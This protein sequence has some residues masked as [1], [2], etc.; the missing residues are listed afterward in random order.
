MTK[1]DT[2]NPQPSQPPPLFIQPATTQ[3][4]V[5]HPA[6][7]HNLVH[8]P[9]DTTTQIR[10]CPFW[11]RRQR[12]LA[13][14]LR[15][16]GKLSRRGSRV[17]GWKRRSR[18]AAAVVVRLYS[19]FLPNTAGEER[20]AHRFHSL[21]RVGRRTGGMAEMRLDIKCIVV[22]GAKSL[23]IKGGSFSIQRLCC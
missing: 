17:A 14:F 12:L 11:N 3:P 20:R 8:T 23:I 21:A 6:E 22:L 18:V 9:H 15:I 10:P 4:L 1:A 5:S 19:R 16:N 7:H 2:S 13:A